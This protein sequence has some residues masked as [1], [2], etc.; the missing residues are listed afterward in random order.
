MDGESFAPM[1][2]LPSLEFNF[3]AL[4][5]TGWGYSAL[6]KCGIPRIQTVKTLTGENIGISLGFFISS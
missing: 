6:G 3:M 2:S 4:L 5:N 1:T